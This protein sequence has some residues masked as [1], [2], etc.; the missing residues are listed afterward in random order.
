MY[1]AMLVDDEY[2]ILEGLKQIIP[3]Q[4]LGFEIVATARTGRE[5]LNYLS[6]YPIDLVVSDITMPEMTGIEMVEQAQARGY[7]FAA[8][9][10]SGYQE[11][12]YVKEGI[13]LGVKDY[14]VKPVDQ[15]ELTEIVKKIYQEL[16]DQRY[17]KDQEQL[18]SENS[19]SRWLN[20]EL[21]EHDFF[22]LMNRQKMTPQGPF[23]AI[24]ILSDA[25]Q[26]VTIIKQLKIKGQRLVITGGPLQDQQI[27]LIFQGDA[28]Q[29]KR[30][31]AE[32]KRQSSGKLIFYTGETILDWENVYESYEKVLQIEELNTFYPDLL[33]NQ[34]LELVE[35]L[36]EQEF[37][38]LVFNKSLM[39]GDAKTIQQE[40]DK[41][42]EEVHLQHLQPENARYIAFL[43]FTDISRQYPTATKVIYEETIQKIR[44]STTVYQ[45]KQ[46]LEEVL[47]LVSVQPVEKQISEATQQVIEIV[48]KDYSQDLNLKLVADELHLNA[49]YLGQ[50]F[51]KEMHSSFAQYLNQVRIKK[52]QQL[53]LYSNQNINEIADETGYNNT[54]YFSKMFKKLNGIT[55]KEFREQYLMDYS[56]VDNKEENE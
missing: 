51:K 15:E 19:I 16:T 26:L 18:Y 53:L 30:F 9:F 49:V 39:I 44:Q 31:L 38:F 4:E 35:N 41:I 54:N 25:S 40:L 5:A 6:K 21:N 1:K 55:P 42:F 8:I 7:E 56:N 3:W 11:F 24:R 28:E 14:L 22:E 32:L 13:R 10:L 43:L 37:S 34:K 36:N 29:L 20:D 12:E 2:M 45:L 23:T 27:T 50:L 46:V 47:Q 17:L 33:P 52:A 48:R